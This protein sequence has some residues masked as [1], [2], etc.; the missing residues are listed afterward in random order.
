MD[1]IFNQLTHL[2]HPK[3]PFER[4][5]LNNINLEMTSKSFTSIVGET[6]SGKSTL[7]QHING[8][9]KP[10][11]G[12]IQI[13]SLSIEAGKKVSNLKEL[14]KQVGMVFQYPEHQLFEETVLKD[15]C[16]GPINFG[17]PEAEA[18][19]RAQ[20][21]IKQVG[22]DTDILSR[23]PFDLSGGQMRR[24]AIA[25]VLAI[26]PKVVI[27]DEPTAGLDPKGRKDIMSLFKQLHKERQWTTI[28]VTHS[29]E[30][31]AYYSDQI[32]VMNKGTVAMHDS[33]EN[34]FIQIDELKKLGLDLP[35]T[36]QFLR[37]FYAKQKLNDIKPVFSIEE[38]ADEIIRALSGEKGVIR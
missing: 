12:S 5:A 4:I 18:E 35:Q 21:A 13:G 33:P 23:S 2:Y 9:L 36:M 15:I 24:V 31:A 38:T 22:L 7:V 20:W 37:L 16:F 10:S 8:L 1:I 29:M 14:R 25:G 3:T 17:V 30:D 34:V 6:G 19:R 26:D 28:M 32:V 11:S 27:L